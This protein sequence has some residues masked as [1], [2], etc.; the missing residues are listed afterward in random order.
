[1]SAADVNLYWNLVPGVRYHLSAK[2]SIRVRKQFEIFLSPTI[3]GICRNAV[4]LHNGCWPLARTEIR[5]TFALHPRYP[6]VGREEK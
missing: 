6:G 3:S 2:P 1:M 4:I 5:A